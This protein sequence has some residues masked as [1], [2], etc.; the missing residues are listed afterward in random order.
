MEFLK[1]IAKSLVGLLVLNIVLVPIM[2]LGPL[3]YV[4]PFFCI[5]ANPQDD[6]SGLAQLYFWLG[7][8]SCAFWMLLS[9]HWPT[10]RRAQREGRLETWRESEGGMLHTVTKATVYMFAGLFGSFIFE[11]TFLVVFSFRPGNPYRDMLWFAILPFAT[12]APVILLWLSRWMR[13]RKQG[14]FISR[15]KNDREL[16]DQ[17]RGAS[18]YGKNLR[19]RNA[20]YRAEEG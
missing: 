1:G 9:C 18:L 12:F 3:L 8:L 19:S 16:H 10:V 17:L 4:I 6:F 13:G 2:V 11:I 15:A 7:P 5:I 20:Q 14:D